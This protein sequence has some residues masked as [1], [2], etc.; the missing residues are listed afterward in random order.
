MLVKYRVIDGVWEEMY[1][2]NIFYL[3][4]DKSIVSQAEIDAL[5]DEG[6]NNGG[7]TSY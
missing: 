6:T 5:F 3:V 1:S 2:K 7:S 4:D